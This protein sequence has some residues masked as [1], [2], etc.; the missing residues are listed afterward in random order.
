[1]RMPLDSFSH[2]LHRQYFFSDCRVQDTVEKQDPNKTV[3]D[4]RL[5]AQSR[6]FTVI[7]TFTPKS[8]RGSRQAVGVL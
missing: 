7:R 4:N 3:L 6:I 2:G 1:Q 5:P 8:K